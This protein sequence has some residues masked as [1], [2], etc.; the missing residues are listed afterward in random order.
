[1][2]EATPNYRG[3]ELWFPVID[4]WCPSIEFQDEELSESQHM[5]LSEPSS[6]LNAMPPSQEWMK[7]DD[8]VP[9]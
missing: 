5:Y 1:M 3:Q 4:Y 6:S 8:D 9:F 7:F 2:S